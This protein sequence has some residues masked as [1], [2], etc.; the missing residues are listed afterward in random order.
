MNLGFGEGM[1]VGLERS[2]RAAARGEKGKVFDWDKAAR[3][4]VETCAREASAGLAGDWG[5]TGGEIWRDGKPVPKEDTYT[6]LASLWATPELDLDG[7][8]EDCWIAADE[9]EW[10]SRTYWPDSA[11]AIIQE[12]K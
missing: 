5:Y 12:G 4:I 8:V 9:T 1:L 6:Y 3:R 7:N 2:R 11:L 10:D